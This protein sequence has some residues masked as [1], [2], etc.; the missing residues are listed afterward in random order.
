MLSPY[1]L[2]QGEYR[3]HAY[4]SIPEAGY[5]AIVAVDVLEH[6]RTTTSQH[7]VRLL[8]RGGLFFESSPFDNAS[9]DPL[10]IHQRASVVM[11]EALQG[12]E[13]EG[14]WTSESNVAQDL[15][16]KLFRYFLLSLRVAGRE[17]RA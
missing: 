3:F 13:F 16:R 9:D 4:R 2:V 8:R 17:R 7:Q 14:P 1:A 6:I 12:L 11:A 15:S 10:A 5:G